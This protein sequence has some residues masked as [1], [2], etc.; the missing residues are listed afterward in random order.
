MITTDGATVKLSTRTHPLIGNC[1]PPLHT[2]R[3]Q[4]NPRKSTP[5]PTIHRLSSPISNKETATRIAPHKPHPHGTPR[6]PC[7]SHIRPTHMGSKF[8]FLLSSLFTADVILGNVFYFNGLLT[9]VPFGQVIDKPRI[10]I[11]PLQPN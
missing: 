1:P 9:T 4:F 11:S 3:W 8:L 10:L 2:S 6:Q 7:P 5:I